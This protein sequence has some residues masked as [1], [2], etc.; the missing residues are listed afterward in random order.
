MIVNLSSLFLR[1]KIFQTDHL[2]VVQHP[3]P[4]YPVHF[5]IL[6]K[7]KIA[8]AIEIDADSNFWQE[9]PKAIQALVERTISEGDGYRIITTGGT[10]Q[11]IPLFH[12]HFV[13]GDPF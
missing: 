10:Y 3:K 9:V 12:I 2:F 5:L 13:S 1:D 4:A 8:D 11:E 7:E 6:P